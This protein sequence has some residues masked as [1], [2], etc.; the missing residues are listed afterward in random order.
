[1]N[2]VGSITKR[3]CKDVYLVSYGENNSIVLYAGE[4]VPYAVINVPTCRKPTPNKHNLTLNDII[5]SV[6]E[7][8]DTFR[9]RTMNAQEIVLSIAQDIDLEMILNDVGIPSIN[10]NDPDDLL[11][12]QLLSHDCEFLSMIS[13]DKNFIFKLQKYCEYLQFVLQK[14]C[15]QYYFSGVYRWEIMRSQCPSVLYDAANCSRIP[16]CHSCVECLEH[17]EC[18]HTC[19]MSWFI[20]V[21]LKCGFLA[22]ENDSLVVSVSKLGKKYVDDENE[23]VAAANKSPSLLNVCVDG[24]LKACE[25]EMAHTKTVFAEI[26]LDVYTTIKSAQDHL[27]NVS[28]LQKEDIN[29]L[30]LLVQK[31]STPEVYHS[32]SNDEK[33]VF[34]K[35]LTYIVDV[36]GNPSRG[37]RSFIDSSPYGSHFFPITRFISTLWCLCY[38]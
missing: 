16:L 18:L 30:N 12:L 33:V 22:K 28:S 8:S 20:S 27:R 23:T 26:P 4:I 24:S 5:E 35:Y 11:T 32:T 1:M 15:H 36:V 6:R 37:G 21:G 14:N 3:V 7:I 29:F 17:G 13:S 31:F 2:V 9:A 10:T 19:C 38:K 34:Q 25:A